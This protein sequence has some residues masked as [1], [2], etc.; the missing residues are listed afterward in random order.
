MEVFQTYPALGLVFAG[1]FGL[2]FGSFGNVIIARLPKMLSAQWQRECAESF[3]E[4]KLPAES[5]ERFNLAY[6]ASHCPH[7]GHNIRWFENI[8]LFS[9]LFLRGRCRGCQQKI[10]LRYPITELLS[11]LLTVAAVA[12]FGFNGVGLAFAVLLY[13]LL[14]L[15]MI[16]R[17]TMLLPDQITLPLLWLGLLLSISVL[18][19]SPTDAIIG[20]A[21]GYLSL[22]SVFWLF[23]L[24]T[25][26]EGMGYGDFKLLAVLGVWLG[27]QMLPLIVLLSSL[28][29]A[30]YGIGL[31]VSKR[32]QH[33]QPMPFGPFL[34]IAGVIALFY[35]QEIYTAYWQ[36]MI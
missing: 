4:V 3:P 6:P 2:V 35:G 13:A 17:E 14:I 10:S 12:H 33:S 32:Q 8:P 9:Y 15:T 5:A 28:V 21:A 20:G 34:A 23:K 24:L 31:I 16:D 1:L 19:V 29:G 36:M 30:V 18:P 25:G 7:C 22:W 11:G 27:W 26:K